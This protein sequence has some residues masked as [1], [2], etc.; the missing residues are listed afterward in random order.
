MRELNSFEIEFVSGGGGKGGGG[1]SK[2]RDGGGAGQPP[3]GTLE[4]PTRGESVL[5]QQINDVA[6]AL[7]SLGHWLGPAIYDVTHGSMAQ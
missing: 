4:R 2:P 1:G 3:A 5:G 7:N 6:G